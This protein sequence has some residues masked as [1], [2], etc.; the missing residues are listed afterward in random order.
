M[1]FSVSSRRRHTRCALVTVVQT[2]ALPILAAHRR[3]RPLWPR[4]KSVRRGLSDGRDLWHAGPLGDRRR[5]LGLLMHRAAAL[6]IL[7]ALAGCQPR[8]PLPALRG[9]ASIDFC[10]D[11]M[12]LGL[13]P[14]EK[15]R[16][17]SFEADSD[18]SFAVP[19][20][21]G[22]ERFRPPLEDIVAARP[23]VVVRSYC[24]DARLDGQL[25]AM[26][27]RG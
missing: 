6:A 12:V 23:A 17:V 7:A 13:L 10:A 3:H 26:G 16:A 19:R 21:L 1:V 25:K 11:Q 18:T 24:G 22:I 20:A 14:K 27:S 8:A 2:C 5:T 4:R 9:V 15:I